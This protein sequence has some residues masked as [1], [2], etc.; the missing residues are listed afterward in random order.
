MDFILDKKAQEAC[1]NTIVLSGSARSGTTILGK[2]LHSFENVEYAFEPPTLFAVMPL[3]DSMPKNQWQLIYE[4]FLYEEFFINAISGRAI[5]CNR[6]DDSSIYNVKSAAEIEERLATSTS[7]LAAEAQIHKHTIAYKMPDIVKYLP[8]L[9]QLYP[10]HQMIIATR[11]APQVFSSMFRKGWFD[12]E[13][14]QVNNSIWPCY[15][16][17]DKK[18]PFWVENNDAEE[19]LDMDELHRIAYYYIMVNQPLESMPNTYQVK[20]DELIANPE[21]VITALAE[22]LG[23]AFG[24]KTK[25]LLGSISRQNEEASD[26]LLAGLTRSVRE[27]VLAYSDIS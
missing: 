11:K 25:E 1:R 14:L 24:E 4:T 23:L 21:Q 10:D 15:L 12:D 7:K 8:S 19:W 20:Y 13:S 6:A 27:Q 16:L 18:I 3:I 26:S 5:N 22:H 9:E 2:L 17:Q